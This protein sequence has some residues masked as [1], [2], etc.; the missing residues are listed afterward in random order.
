MRDSDTGTA[1]EQNYAIGDPAMFRDDAWRPLFARLRAEDPVHWSAQ[2]RTGPFWSVMR[3]DDILTV[4]SDH[5]RFSASLEHGGVMLDRRPAMRHFHQMDPP[6]HGV[7][8]KALAPAVGGDNLKRLEELLRLQARRILAELPTDSDFD[9]VERVSVELT[10]MML[11]TL[12]G[13]PQEERHA[14]VR[15]SDMLTA[16]LDDPDTPFGEEAE[17]NAAVAGFFSDMLM[18]WRR[19]RRAPEGEDVVSTMA[20]SEAMRALPLAEISATLALMLFAANDTSRNAMSGGVWAFSQFPDQW[21]MLRKRPDLLP[22]AVLEIMRYQTPILYDG[23]TATRDVELGGK[24]IRSG[25]RVVIWYLSGNRD[26]RVFDD[27]E[28]FRIDRPNA[29]RHLAF[30][31]GPHRC[32]GAKLAEAQLR[33]LWEEIIR[34]GLEIEVLGTP[35]YAYSNFVRGIV[36]LPVR[37]RKAGG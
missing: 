30:G 16:D 19:R 24:L 8:R 35:R 6:E 5:E 36:S 31:A 21:R 1:P 11:A 23:R 12:F 26:E 4:D 37:L 18:L 15:R 2:G 27:A 10:S 33:I 32:L 22:N 9:W 28:A 7:R 14:L 29:R 13:L 17:R 34:A 3:H 25:D 20:R